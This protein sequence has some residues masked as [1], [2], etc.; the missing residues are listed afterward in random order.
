ME[1]KRNLNGTGVALV[2]PFLEDKSPDYKAIEKLVNHVS[3][4]GVV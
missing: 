2:T 3:N 1:N 4:G